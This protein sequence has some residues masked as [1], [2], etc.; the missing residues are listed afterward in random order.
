MIVPSSWKLGTR[1]FRSRPVLSH[2][3]PEIRYARAWACFCALLSSCY[4]NVPPPL[5]PTQ[6]PVWNPDCVSSTMSFKLQRLVLL[7]PWNTTP[8]LPTAITCTSTSL[9]PRRLERGYVFTCSI[10]RFSSSNIWL[11]SN[12][13]Q[14]ISNLTS[15]HMI[16]C[17]GVT[18]FR[19]G[20]LL[21]WAS[22][23]LELLEWGSWE[24]QDTWG[25]HQK[26]P[27]ATSGEEGMGW[28][29]GEMVEP[30][31]LGIPS[32][33]RAPTPTFGSVSA[34]GE[35]LLR[36]PLHFFFCSEMLCISDHMISSK[37]CCHL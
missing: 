1:I 30:P 3:I 21:G 25:H 4:H 14:N 31:H 20:E 22:R 5:S 7:C 27:S 28:N 29:D 16:T 11:L 8:R 37:E 23:L 34:Q 2:P 10:L 13:Q 18:F 24:N 19:E 32:C 26:S 35:S 36:L 12:I 17:Y 9:V 6:N 33:K 15:A